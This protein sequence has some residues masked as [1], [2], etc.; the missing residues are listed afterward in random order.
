MSVPL[1][2]SAI[3]GEFIDSANLRNIKD[4]I[5]YAPGVTGSSSDSYI[6][7]VSIRGIY[8]QDFG[9][10]GD[11]SVAFYKDSL[12][13]GRD[14]SAVSSLYDI[15][16]AE[17]LRGPQGF[18]FGR[19]S[20][21]GAISVVTVKPDLSK[22]GGYLDV[23]SGSRDYLT[24]DGA[25]NLQLTDTL[26]VRLA[27]YHG[28]ED[29]FVNNRYPVPGSEKNGSQDTDALRFSGLYQSEKLQA[30][31]TAEYEN[32]NLSGY[33]YIP[34]G[35]GEGYEYLTELYGDLGYPASDWVQYA[36]F[37]LGNRDNAE[38]SGY[39]LQ[40]D[41]D[42]GFATLTSITGYRDHDFSYAEDFDGTSVLLSSFAQDQS[43]DY[44][45]QELRLVSRTEGPLSW[46]S[47][48]SFYKENIDSTYRDQ[49]SED[50]WCSTFLAEF[51][52][53]CEV[54][55]DAVAGLAAIDPEDEFVQ[56]FLDFF[57]TFD[58]QGS[59]SGN[60]T[61]TN[62][63]SGD[64][65]GYAAYVDLGY[66]FNDHWKANA[67]VRYTRDEKDFSINAFPNESPLLGNVAVLFFSTPEGPVKDSRNWDHFTPR[68]ILEYTPDADT[69]LFGSVTSGYKS[70][71][72]NSFGLSPPIDFYVD[73]SPD[74]YKPGSYQPEKSTSYELGYKET[75]FQGRTQIAVNTFYY[76]YS[77]LQ[78]SYEQGSLFIVDNIGDAEGWGMES[79]LTQALG[80]YLDLNAAVA[81]FD[82]KVNNL[83]SACGGT[84]LCEGASFFWAPEWSGHLLLAGQYPYRKGELVGNLG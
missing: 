21:A 39:G 49:Q 8:T 45:E 84:E 40:L 1:A 81:W 15:E 80:N 27:A 7:N 13:Q 26:A 48:V 60:L 33:N 76:R 16:R 12:Y 66:A 14:G 22:S 30:H 52:T 23:A 32:R 46:Y 3:S 73:A 28:E 4:V 50:V 37:S 59:A 78:V 58:W 35:Q 6:N 74:D 24:A 51:D 34:T 47:G 43:G 77:D 55:F 79:A 29:G 18:L 56:E 17:I 72:F 70:G 36:D 68:F 38:I 57:G 64:Y 53:S 41:Y 71:G 5:A 10:G 9:A 61:D 65:E 62:R 67:G 69:L 11:P 2:I 31:F 25:F 44:F 19:G 54:V 75:L 63:V 83:Q 42:L 20:I 82:S